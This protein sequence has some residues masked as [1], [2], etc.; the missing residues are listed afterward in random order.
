MMKKLW[1]LAAP[2]AV[3]SFNGCGGGGIVPGIPISTATPAPN[4]TA[5]PVPN[6]TA[7]PA[8][9]STATPVPNS[10]ATPT[11]NA[12]ATPAPSATPVGNA[13]FP[14]TNVSR[15]SDV[16]RANFVPGSVTSNYSPFDRN[17]DIRLIQVLGSDALG[18]RQRSVEISE[19]NRQGLF[20]NNVGRS[21]RIGSGGSVNGAPTV[22]VDYRQDNPL[23]STNRSSRWRAISG[24]VVIDAYRRNSPTTEIV[25]FRLINARFSPF[26]AATGNFN[27]SLNGTTSGQ[28]NPT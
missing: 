7:T 18:Q 4:S 25:T 5:T 19:N 17:S 26:F 20:E 8:P 14:I 24:T 13:G 2:V 23:G 9:N 15:G 6:S 12:T 28:R 27:L 22:L 1:L 21:L 3:L 16:N 10:T 11:P